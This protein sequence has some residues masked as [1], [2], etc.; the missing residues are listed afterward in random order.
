[1]NDTAKIL[2]VKTSKVIAYWFM[3]PSAFISAMLIKLA[4]Q[5]WYVWLILPIFLFSFWLGI[6]LFR[7][8]KTLIKVE[9]KELWLYEGS[10][11]AETEPKVKIPF[12][13]IQ[14]FDVQ[15]FRDNRG[16]SWFLTITL[17][18]PTQL[19]QQAQKSISNSV[20]FTKLQVEPT[21]IPW[22]LNWPEGGAKKLKQRLEEII[23]LS[24]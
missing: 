15:M 19:S 14:S 7:H 2:T 11:M 12:E 3:L 1:M 23:V 20:R 6:K 16:A 13:L 17:K 22:S 18:Q 24:N 5:D 4:F 10:L 9:N 21:F 8:P